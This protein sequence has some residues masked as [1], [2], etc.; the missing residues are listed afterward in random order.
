MYI[1]GVLQVVF[2][3]QVCVENMRSLNSEGFHN[4]ILI[5]MLLE[6]QIISKSQTCTTHLY[7]CEAMEL[8]GVQNNILLTDQILQICN[9]LIF[10]YA[11]KN[12][13]GYGILLGF[14]T[15]F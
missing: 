11:Q 8:S 2:N 5:E 1:H 14:Y 15:I 6:D 7:S 12:T 10:I 4:Y 9:S 13:G 3:I